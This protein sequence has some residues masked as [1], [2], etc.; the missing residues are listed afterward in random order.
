MSSCEAALQRFRQD[1]ISSKCTQFK[2]NNE[3]S[4]EE[5]KNET[6]II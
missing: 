4:V 1:R 6:K 3:L 2:I 5:V